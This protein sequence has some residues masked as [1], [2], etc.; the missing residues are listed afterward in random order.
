MTHSLA[1]VEPADG[2]CSKA[3]TAVICGASRSWARANCVSAFHSAPTMA[4]GLTMRSKSAA[5]R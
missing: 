5:S 1:T 4:A 2:V 3:P